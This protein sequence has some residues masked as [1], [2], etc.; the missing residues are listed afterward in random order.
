MW[1]DPVWAVEQVLIV[2]YSGYRLG[3]MEILELGEIYSKEFVFTIFR[4]EKI[5]Q[6]S[7]DSNLQ[8]QST[9]QSSNPMLHHTRLHVVLLI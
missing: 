4:K 7:Q 8:F 1:I 2:L 3:F 6:H 9:A 5:S